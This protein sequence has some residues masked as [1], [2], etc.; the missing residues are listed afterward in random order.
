MNTF[1][2]RIRAFSIDT[3]ITFVCVL[4]LIPLQINADIK[5]YLVFGIYILVAIVPYLFGTGQTFGKRVQKLKVVKNTKELVIT[6]PIVPNR[7]YLV[8]R[9]LTKCAFIIMTFGFY[10]IIS[11]IIA[12]N[13]EDGR[14]IHDYIFKT[15]VIP[16][17]RYVTDRTEMN[18]TGAAKESLKGYSYNDK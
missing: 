6:D 3:S 9:E 14:T 13:H 16:L 11:A 10:I 5:K 2:R 17:T 4:F 18:R 12:T 7:F 15:R 1:D 8:L